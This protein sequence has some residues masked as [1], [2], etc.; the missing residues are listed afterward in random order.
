MVR[1][2]CFVAGPCGLLN[3]LGNAFQLGFLRSKIKYEYVMIRVKQLRI[4]MWDKRMVNKDI[5]ED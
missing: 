2:A 4:T 3:T 1:P 5:S